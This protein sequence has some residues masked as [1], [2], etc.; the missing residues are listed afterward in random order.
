MSTLL[1]HDQR[2]STGLSTQDLR[3]VSER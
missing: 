1:L 2:Y 3:K